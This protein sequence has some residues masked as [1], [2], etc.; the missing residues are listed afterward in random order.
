MKAPFIFQYKIL[1]QKMNENK[2]DFREDLSKALEKLREGKLIIVPGDTGW[3]ICCDSTNASAL[4]LM[5]R[6]IFCNAEKKIGL[7]TDNVGKIANYVETIPELA[8][9]LFELKTKPL[10]I[11]FEGG[12]NLPE[13]LTGNDKFIGF[14]IT[15][16]I[17]LKKL[18]E[19]HRKPIAICK[20]KKS[21]TK[22]PEKKQYI[23]SEIIKICDSDIN[24]RSTESIKEQFASVI[25]LGSGNRIKIISE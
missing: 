3:A 8:W 16:D 15:E 23:D 21:G 20:A 19:R 6:T 22:L 13:I 11:V 18:C 14:R 25:F 4:Q 1:Q 12:K 7:I 5:R 9:D 17:F 2:P 24:Y 10:T